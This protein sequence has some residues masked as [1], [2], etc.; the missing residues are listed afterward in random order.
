MVTGKD[1]VEGP[2]DTPCIYVSGESNKVGMITNCNAASA[3][4]FGYKIK[5]MINQ[6]VEKLMPEMYAKEDSNVLEEALAK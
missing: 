6:N 4:V 1:A 5:E 2:N 3:R